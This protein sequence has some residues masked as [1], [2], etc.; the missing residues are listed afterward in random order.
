ML[1]ISGKETSLSLQN[2]NSSHVFMQQAETVRLLSE[3]PNAVSVTE[4][5]PQNS[6]LGWVGHA[7]RHVGLP[8][9]G[10]IEER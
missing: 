7:A 4:L 5:A 1:K 2:A 8:V 9:K 6:V 10:E 3:E